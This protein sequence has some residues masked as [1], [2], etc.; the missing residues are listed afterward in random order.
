V[1]ALATGT[2]RASP[3]KRNESSSKQKHDNGLS[4]T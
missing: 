4:R 3:R 1:V 2:A